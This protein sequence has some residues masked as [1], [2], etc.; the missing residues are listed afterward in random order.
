MHAV[1][2]RTVACISRRHVERERR[3]C[4]RHAGAAGHSLACHTRGH[5]RYDFVDPST[6]HATLETQ[7]IGGLFLAGQINGTTGYEEAAAQGVVAGASLCGR[8]GV[9]AVPSGAVEP[10]QPLH[11]AW[12]GVAGR[13]VAWRGASV[14]FRLLQAQMQRARSW[15]S[16]H[17]CLAVPTRT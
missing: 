2:D 9:Y 13:G 14:L 5:C 7:R 15:A 17:C 6:L 4:V 1:H 16:H 11:V 3:S 8:E 12:R 10:C